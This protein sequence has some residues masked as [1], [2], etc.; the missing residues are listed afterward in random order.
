VSAP[1]EKRPGATLAGATGRKLTRAAYY[2]LDLLQVPF[3]FAF[4]LIEQRKAR[5]QDRIANEQSRQ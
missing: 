2:A 5:L 4:W 3:G 1:G